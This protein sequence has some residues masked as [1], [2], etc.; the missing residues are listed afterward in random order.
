MNKK[1]LDADSPSEVDDDVVVSMEYRLTVEGA[2]VDSTEGEE[3]LEYL[4]GYGNIVD[5]LEEALYGLKIGD[6]KEV[7][8]APDDGYGVYDEDA[9]AEVPRSDFPREIPL[10]IGVEIEME[11]DDGEILDAMIV[12]V[13]PDLVKLDFNHPLAGKT[14]NFWVKIVALRAG[15]EEEIDHGHVHGADHDEDI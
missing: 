5:G 3:P 8:V 4:H 9:V 12:E 13:G 6:E 11:D 2:V 14:L 1:K 15:T 7:T 10:E